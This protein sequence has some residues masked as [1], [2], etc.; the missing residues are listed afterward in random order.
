[1]IIKFEQLNGIGITRCLVRTDDVVYVGS[2]KCLGCKWYNTINLD[3]S[4]VKCNH[5]PINPFKAIYR[6]FRSRKRINA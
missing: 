2:I 3:E 4:K 6:Y 5:K 1:M